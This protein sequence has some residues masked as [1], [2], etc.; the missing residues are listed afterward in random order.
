MFQIVNSTTVNI[1]LYQYTVFEWRLERLG[2]I[3]W[4][5]RDDFFNIVYTKKQEKDYYYDWYI[6]HEVILAEPF[7][8]GRMGYH[9]AVDEWNM[10]CCRIGSLQ[11]TNGNKFEIILEKKVNGVFNEVSYTTKD[12]FN[13]S[14]RNHV[15]PFF[16]LR[17]KIDNSYSVSTYFLH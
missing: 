5:G 7:K 1:D 9:L 16:I 17:N 11:K 10:L 8:N 4:I 2:A 14:L 12:F 6:L 3:Y 15:R 13:C